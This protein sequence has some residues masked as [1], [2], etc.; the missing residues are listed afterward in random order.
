VSA[1]VA[2]VGV[3][4]ALAVIVLG[5]RVSA[6]LAPPRPTSMAPPRRRAPFG[7]RRRGGE[8]SPDA[9][10]DWCELVARSL[11]SGSSLVAAVSDAAG[12]DS[13]MA[14]VIAPVVGQVGRGDS[15]VAAIDRRDV[16][17]ASAPGLSLAVI[18]ACARFGGPAAVPLERAA[19]TLRAREAI[20]A[21]QRAQSAQALMSARVLTLVPVA[22]LAVLAITDAKVRDAITTPAGTAAVLLGAA[23]NATG[24]LWM[25]RIIGH[26]R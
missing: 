18:R 2:G 22:L 20:A 7:I 19:A 16:D 9:V 21:E 15:L 23:L 13:P 14:P 25:R 11:R 6:A 26:P 17:P 3:A 10:A 8:P 1:E 5:V 24:A 4:A 12:A